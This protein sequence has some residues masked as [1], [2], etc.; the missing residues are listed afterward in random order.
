MNR[1]FQ[2]FTYTPEVLLYE[3]PPVLVPLGLG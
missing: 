3:V 2:L 1:M